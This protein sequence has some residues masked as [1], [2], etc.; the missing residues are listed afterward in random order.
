[1]AWPSQSAPRF[2]LRA[3]A[4]TRQQQ[5]RHVAHFFRQFFPG[6]LDSSPHLGCVQ[7]GQRRAKCP[8][9][10][11][12]IGARFVPEGGRDY[13]AETT[14]WHLSKLA[15]EDIPASGVVVVVVLSALRGLFGSGVQQ[16]PVAPR[17]HTLVRAVRPSPRRATPPFQPSGRPIGRRGLEHIHCALLA[18]VPRLPRARG[19]RH[20][21]SHLARCAACPKYTRPAI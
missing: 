4:A 10:R 20:A 21:A 2:H 6:R 3:R 7:S 19:T 14:W 9:A 13:V 17:R 8:T 15:C 1:M 18:A 12:S 5:A 11:P 16:G